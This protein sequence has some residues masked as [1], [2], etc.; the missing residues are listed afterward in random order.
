MLYFCHQIVSRADFFI[1]SHHSVVKLQIWFDITV[2]SI[3]HSMY[4]LRLLDSNESDIYNQG[5]SGTT[6]NIL[7]LTKVILSTLCK[8]NADDLQ[9][10]HKHIQKNFSDKL[11]EWYFRLQI[12]FCEFVEHVVIM[13]YVLQIQENI[14]VTIRVSLD[15]LIVFDRM[16]K[17]IFQFYRKVTWKF[18]IF[19]R[20]FPNC[21]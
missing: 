5:I 17:T 8:S 4:I 16:R 12:T 10:R 9:I 11:L 7:S 13:F 6:N 1:K 19:L 21:P 3:T 2:I 15:F 20:T 18:P 14:M